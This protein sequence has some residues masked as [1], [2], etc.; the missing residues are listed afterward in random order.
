[1]LDRLRWFF[2]LS[3]FMNWTKNIRCPSL[4]GRTTLRSNV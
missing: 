3:S 2:V 4:K 1:L